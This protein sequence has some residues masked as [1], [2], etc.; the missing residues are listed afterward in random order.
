MGTSSSS[1][2]TAWHASLTI[3]IHVLTSASSACIICQ[4]V[5]RSA[6]HLLLVSMHSS[7]MNC[8]HAHRQTDRQTYRPTKPS[9]RLRRQTTIY[10]HSDS[11]LQ[12]SSLAAFLYALHCYSTCLSIILCSCRLL[13]SFP[14]LYTQTLST[15]RIT[16]Q[17]FRGIR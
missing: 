6:H 15:S 11:A 8:D 12:L 2:S 14:L 17:I 7:P 10:Q 5:S 3:C 16:A 9:R 13:Q 4:L 1:S